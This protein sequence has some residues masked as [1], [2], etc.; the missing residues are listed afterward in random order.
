MDG[1]TATRKIREAPGGEDVKIAALTASVLKEEREAALIAGSDDFV[2]KPFK[3]EEIFDCMKRHL[4]IHYTYAGASGAH[5]KHAAKSAALSDSDLE[6]LPLSLLEEMD[7][8]AQGGEDALLMELISR[9]T[10]IKAETQSALKGIIE[11][12]RFDQLTC[13]IESALAKGRQ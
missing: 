4:N 1:L 6:G 13:L 7:E 3:P 11:E 9:S 10:D 12:Y 2:C 8:A 5:V